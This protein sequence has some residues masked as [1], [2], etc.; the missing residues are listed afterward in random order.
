MEGLPRAVINA[1]KV[2][3]KAFDERKAEARVNE[4]LVSYAPEEG[5]AMFM[6][7]DLLCFMH[8][9]LG[10]GAVGRPPS[11]DELIPHLLKEVVEL[12]VDR[13]VPVVGL[14][15]RSQRKPWPV[16]EEVVLDLPEQHV[17]KLYLLEG[18]FLVRFELCE[19]LDHL[20]V[21]E[22]AVVFQLGEAQLEV[23]AAF[24][25][26]SLEHQSQQKGNEEL[27]LLLLREAKH[28]DVFYIPR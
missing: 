22:H 23:E 4:L 28:A 14:Q 15:E 26:L 11:R 13:L 5:N 24:H 16:R 27:L 6:R 20:V 2:F 8:P 9:E 7:T 19:G 17:E 21:K 1:T 10:K 12:G 18:R 3:S 25:D